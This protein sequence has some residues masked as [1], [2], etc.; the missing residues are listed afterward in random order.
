MLSRLKVMATPTFLYPL[1]TVVVLAV[2]FLIYFETMTARAEAV[3]NE[4]SFRALNRVS[5]QFRARAENVAHAFKNSWR[6]AEQD[7]LAMLEEARESG[8][9]LTRE[10]YDQHLYD[11]ARYIA[12]QLPAL[13]VPIRCEQRPGAIRADTENFPGK[14]AVR[15]TYARSSLEIHSRGACAALDFASMLSPYLDDDTLK[16][17]SDILLTSDRGEVL[18]QSA[19]AGVRVQDARAL[20]HRAMP[21]EA[22]RSSSEPSPP[23]GA[24][25][26][27]DDAP[28]PWMSG[29]GK[30][31]IKLGG[32]TQIMFVVPVRLAVVSDALERA[33][34]EHVRLASFAVIGL[35]DEGRFRNESRSIPGSMLL[36]SVLFLSIVIAASWPLLKFT[37]IRSTE[38]IQ[39]RSGLLY[40]WTSILTGS[41]VVLLAIQL[42]YGDGRVREELAQLADAIDRNVAVEVSRALDTLDT[43]SAS[44][45]TDERWKE[46]DG[47]CRPDSASISEVKVPRGNLLKD[48]PRRDADYPYYEMAFWGDCRGNQHAKWSVR[49]QVTAPV[50]LST[51]A[52]FREL[53]R[54]NLWS[55]ANGEVPRRDQFRV[56]PLFSPNDAGYYAVVSSTRS[57]PHAGLKT[58]SLVTGALSLVNTVLP[59][60][61]GFALI[62]L[63]GSV[64]FHSDSRRNGIENFFQEC[65]LDEALLGAV[66]AQ[67]PEYVHAKYEGDHHLLFVTPMDR[68]QGSSWTLI[69][70][71]NLTVRDAE[72]VNALTLALVLVLIYTFLLGLFI[73]IVPLDEYPATIYWP[74]RK[75]HSLYSHILLTNVVVVILAFFLVFELPALLLVFF[76]LVLLPLSAVTVVSAKL[77]G[78]GSGIFAGAVVAW[79]LWLTLFFSRQLTPP[80]FALGSA[81]CIAYATLG[82]SEITDFFRRF[83]APHFGSKFALVGLSVIAFGSVVPTCALY[84]LAHNYYELVFAKHSQ[85]HHK[86]AL[87]AREA[88]VEEY[89]RQVTLGDESAVAD[90]DR[91]LFLRR[92]LATDAL[93]RYDVA[94]AASEP[95]RFGRCAD[96]LIWAERQRWIAHAVGWLASLL[97]TSGPALP[98]VVI[99]P[100]RAPG[101]SRHYAPRW[102]WRTEGADRLRYTQLPAGPNDDG[103]AV[104]PAQPPVIGALTWLH[105]PSD[106]FDSLDM[107]NVL[108]PLRPQDLIAELWFA[109]LGALALGFL[110]SRADVKAI[111]GLD[112]GLEGPPAWKVIEAI[113]DPV[114]ENTVVVGAPGSGKTELASTWS[115]CRRIDLASQWGPCDGAEDKTLVVLDHFEY[116]IDDA[117]QTLKKIE[118]IESLIYRSDSRR[119]VVLS[120]IDPLFYI[121]AEL[122]PREDLSVDENAVRAELLRRA[123]ILSGFATRYYE[124]ER[125]LAK[126]RLGATLW[127][128]C[129]TLEKSALLQIALNGWP[130]YKNHEALAH[131]KDRRIL[132]DSP[133]LRIA[134]EPLQHY[135]RNLT[136]AESHSL[137]P[138]NVQSVW[139]AVRLAMT[140]FFLAALGV[141]LYL[142]QNEVLG[143]FVSLFGL[144]APMARFL[145]G[146]SMVRAALGGSDTVEV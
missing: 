83:T 98:A 86:E 81:I 68:I 110:V 143:A 43:L 122:R 25:E 87:V 116:Q 130:N 13:R 16:G 71:R 99:A 63:D 7:T 107:V 120:T 56:D 132:V 35:V 109:G 39:R 121:R 38:S 135:V 29:S 76:A 15:A 103:G 24:V 95:T 26:L 101:R 114:D 73:A 52:F 20:L 67:Y 12:D 77:K 134:D 92:R 11:Q 144:V 17:F 106:H 37:T 113:N 112:V 131:L 85:S 2:G 82:F 62:S 5:A 115:S 44:L 32:S 8:D 140:I 90:L 117:A 136:E 125:R 66:A 31:R 119:V 111:F 14:V 127:G 146:S 47:D 72:K 70:F 137:T 94:S 69:V 105:A 129:T 27:D 96:C 41:L 97:P 22:T 48:P 28:I 138:H 142:S 4:Q 23:D 42:F 74:E 54:G 3:L 75:R 78:A 9:G 51:M 30:Y 133:G 80:A 40:L 6:I 91:R 50:A 84:R 89:Y 1:A 108:S 93:D 126:K 58:A 123:A 21:T 45:I 36:T 10:Q 33:K 59:A 61:Y 104:R 53:L 55:I 19:H 64:L 65:G 141:L 145:T 79:L 139:S 100:S 49:N 46:P 124:G 128:T 57:L 60:D 88:R 18:Y 34:D 102:E 118:L